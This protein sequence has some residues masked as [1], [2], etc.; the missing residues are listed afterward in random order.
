MTLW[1]KD[2]EARLKRQ[3]MISEPYGFMM[4]QDMYERNK[5]VVRYAVR[6][7]DGFKVPPLGFFLFANLMDRQE[8][9]W[10][11]VFSDERE[12]V[13]Q[14]EESLERWRYVLE[15]RGMAISRDKTKYTCVNE[16]ETGEKVKM[17]GVQIVNSRLV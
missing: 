13:D 4:V 16:R 9:L 1:E 2:A 6:V 5:I 14:V 11:M 3:I 15:R 17:Q 12:Q 10:T 8:S 7:T